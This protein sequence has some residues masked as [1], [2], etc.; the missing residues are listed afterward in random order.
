MENQRD[1]KKNK[2]TWPKP[3][4]IDVGL[5]DEQTTSGTGNQGDQ[6]GTDRWKPTAVNT[7]PKAVLPKGE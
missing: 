4:V 7:Q 6:T 3:K 2:K 1:F 5:I